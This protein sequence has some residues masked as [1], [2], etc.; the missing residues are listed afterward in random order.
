MTMTDAGFW[1]RIAPKYAKSPI[2]NVEAYE[3]TLTRTRDYLRPDHHVVEM[4]CGTGSTALKLAGHV[5]QYRATDVSPGMIAIATEKAEA[6]RTPGLS[7]DV[8]AATAPLAA[9][10]TL[11]AVL[12]F[13]LFHLVPDL[14]ASLAEAYRALKP[15]AV[16]ISKTP[17]LGDMN[18]FVRLLIP[19]MRLVGKA[20][21]VRTFK[22]D[23]L[24]NLI[25]AVGFEI[26]HATH[27][28]G[29]PTSWF[30]VARKPER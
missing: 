15:G 20:P 29:A 18:P 17:C 4:G 30:V 3:T 13:N 19:V 5:A 9:R 22:R 28:A 16:M 23:A 26:E 11:D 6:A 7:F 21:Y 25:R 24:E 10:D 12:S 14:E 8:A 2:K 1:D 27:F